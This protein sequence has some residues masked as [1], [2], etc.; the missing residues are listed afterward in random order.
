MAKGWHCRICGREIEGDSRLHVIGHKKSFCLKYNIPAEHYHKIDWE[1]VVND[2]LFG[3][4]EV[5]EKPKKKSEE[6]KTCLSKWI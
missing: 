1:M 2:A 4:P 3:V 5:P 6:E